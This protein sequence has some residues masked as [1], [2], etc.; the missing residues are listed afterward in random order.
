MIFVSNSVAHHPFAA[1]TCHW[2]CSS[3]AT[4]GVTA[5]PGIVLVVPALF[6][7]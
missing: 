5:S 6:G 1:T 3:N 4:G 2:L 7:K